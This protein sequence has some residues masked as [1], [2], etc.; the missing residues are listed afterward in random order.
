MDEMYLQALAYDEA[1]RLIEKCFSF[2]NPYSNEIEA[3]TVPFNL[4][5]HF[6][7]LVQ[8]ELELKGQRIT[9]RGAYF[10]IDM[11]QAK[12]SH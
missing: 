7:A 12:K 4:R 11:Y 3:E 1:Q 10:K 8:K 2:F 5:D 9:R 6:Y